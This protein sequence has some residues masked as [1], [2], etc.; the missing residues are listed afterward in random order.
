MCSEHQHPHPPETGTTADEQIALLAYMHHHN[1]HHLDEFEEI[2]K[3]LKD[4][5]AAAEL[6]HQGIE[7]LKA[8]NEK[9]AATI[10]ALKEE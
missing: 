3:A 10:T 2:L 9:F 8:A 7:L 4:N 1:E 6:L 5:G